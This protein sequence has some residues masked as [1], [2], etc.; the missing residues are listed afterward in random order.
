MVQINDTFEYKW[1]KTTGFFSN[2]QEEIIDRHLANNE[3]WYV[4]EKLDGCNMSISTEGYIA[5]RLRIIG[6]RDE[7]KKFQSHSLENVLSLFEAVDELYDHLK[8]CFFSKHGLKNVILYGEFM[9]AG[10]ATSKFDIYN[11]VERGYNPTHFY[12]FGIGL[13]FEAITESVQKDVERIFRQAFLQSS[14]K[15]EAFYIVPIDWFLTGLF[16]KLHIDCVRL[17]SVQTLQNVL[18]RSDLINPLLEREL[19]GYILTNLNGKGLLK[20][21]KAPAKS[22]V[23][24]QHLEKLEHIYAPA[25]ATLRKLYNSADHFFTVFDQETFTSVFNAIFERENEF[26]EKCMVREVIHDDTFFGSQMNVQTDRLY[27]LV[28]QKLEDHYG[29][30]LIPQVKCQIKAKIRTKMRVLTKYF[31]RSNGVETK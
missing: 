10:T 5:S 11:Y 8:L 29:K 9:P 16:Y 19:E 22:S 13:Q 3:S 21:K 28:L 4:S 15:Q 12:A 27:H 17:H 18:T 6:K 2:N 14:T 25:L 26:I 24:D 7:V 23:M 20:L 30:K 31:Y 1:P